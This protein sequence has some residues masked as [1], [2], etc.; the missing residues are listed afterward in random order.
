MYIGDLSKF[1]LI[2]AKSNINGIYNISTDQ[3]ISKFEFGIKLAE[4]FGLNKNLIVNSS[5]TKKS[6][7]CKRPTNMALS[8]EK[9]KKKLNLK[10]ISINSNLNNFYKCY[11]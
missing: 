1:I 3:K 2:L 8:N 9:L 11:K 4:T 10:T 7:L 6:S 5:I